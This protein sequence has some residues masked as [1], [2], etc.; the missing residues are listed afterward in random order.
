MFK[1][2]LMLHF[3]C[4]DAKQHQ[5]HQNCI[6]YAAQ[7]SKDA[8]RKTTPNCFS[9]CVCVCSYC[10]IWLWCSIDISNSS[11]VKITPLIIVW[12]THAS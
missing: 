11:I 10:L 6:I 7:N 12:C 2:A 4:T 8:S 9:E 3:I 5:T 1:A